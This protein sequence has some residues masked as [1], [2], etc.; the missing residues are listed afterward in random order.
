MGVHVD[1]ACCQEQHQ[2]YEGMVHHVQECPVGCQCTVFRIPLRPGQAEHPDSYQDEAYL[3][4][5]RAGQRPLQIH[6]AY[7]K[8]SAPQHGGRPQGQYQQAPG[9]VLGEQAAAQDQD[10]VDAGFGQ[11]AGEQGGGG[12]R[13]HGMGL[14]QP[15]VQGEGPGLGA[16]AEEQ[17]GSC[18]VERVFLLAEC[19]GIERVFLL[20]G[21]HCTGQLLDGQ[22]AQLVVEQEDAHE[23]H[24]AP[25]HRYGQVGGG[26]PQRRPVL[27]LGYPYVG[28][29]GHDFKEDK[30]GI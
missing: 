21:C 8:H 22:R 29:K 1:R 20:V 12:G 17:A 19:R 18:G 27:L 2:L 3:G 23:H 14:G 4:H 26:S 25:C 9:P 13:G 7:G 24:Q 6:G 11:D 15:D 10:A 5:G 30:C 16:E 28:G